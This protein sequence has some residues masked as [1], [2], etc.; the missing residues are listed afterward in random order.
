[1]TV[2]RQRRARYEQV[3][4]GLLACPTHA[5][6]AEQGGISL[7]T[8]QR[9]LRRPGFVRLYAS[10]R[11]A[12]LE[13]TVAAL[14]DAGTAAVAA[15]RAIISDPGAAP[16]AKVRAAAVILDRSLRGIQALDLAGRLDNLE[17][18]TRGHGPRPRRVRIEVPGA[19]EDQS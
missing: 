5:A 16:A 1:M 4:A 7:A 18:A 10:A 15:L 17:Q 13:R 8:L 9:W 12:A 11:R 19:L 14:V 3:I 2:R 6:A